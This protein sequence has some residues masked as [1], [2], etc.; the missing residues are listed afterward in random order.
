MKQALAIA[1]FFVGGL[2]CG[3]AGAQKVG[4]ADI[5]GV[6]SGPKG[7][8]AG[9]WVIAETTDL[10]DQVRQGR[11]HRRQ[12]PLPHSRAAQGELHR[13]GERLRPRRLAEDQGRRPGK[14][15]NLKAVAAKN[16]KEAAEYYPG[17]YWYSMLNIP[18]KDQFPGTGEK[19]NGIAPNIK[20]PGSLGRHA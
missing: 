11:R 20:T 4:A 12:G 8:E 19:G 5:G 13:V 16:E 14:T 10:P 7:P 2:F 6:V 3:V 1:L 17:M 9:V 18:A 15:L